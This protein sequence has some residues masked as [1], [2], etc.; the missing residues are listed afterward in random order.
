M[1]KHIKDSKFL[2]LLLRHKPEELNLTIDN[3]GWV[4][5]DQIIKNSNHRFTK[6]N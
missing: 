5:V 6:R 3:E 2:S 4:K 1:N